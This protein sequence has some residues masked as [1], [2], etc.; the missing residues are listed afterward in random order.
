M[1]FRVVDEPEFVVFSNESGLGEATA[2][3]TEAARLRHRPLRPCGG[4]GAA[5]DI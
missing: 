5:Q 4:V 1:T 2:T 3:A